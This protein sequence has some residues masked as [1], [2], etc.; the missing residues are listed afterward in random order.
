MNDSETRSLAVEKVVSACKQHVSEI[1]VLE[2]R[3][4]TDWC[5]AY[6]QSGVPRVT[7][8]SFSALSKTVSPQKV[9]DGGLRIIH[10]TKG[11]PAASLSEAEH[12]VNLL[13]SYADIVVFSP[14]PVA[15]QQVQDLLISW[16]SFWA[17]LF[18]AE[19][20]VLQDI[21]RPAVWDSFY[22]DWDNLQSTVVFANTALGDNWTDSDGDGAN[23]VVDYVHPSSFEVGLRR[24]LALQTSAM[25]NA[26]D[27]SAAPQEFSSKIHIALPKRYS[28]KEYEQKL[29]QESRK[30]WKVALC[31]PWRISYWCDLWRLQRRTKRWSN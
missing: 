23:I 24:Q 8:S 18:L 1:I 15:E 22:S 2:G 19:G 31:S 28:K 25:L 17:L 11:V 3:K 20:F 27:T 21:V 29:F 16:P 4:H 10:V 9:T 6:E 12:S 26:T 30:W 13:T 5:V 7:Q 14:V